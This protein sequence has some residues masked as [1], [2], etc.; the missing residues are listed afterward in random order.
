MNVDEGRGE[1]SGM[2]PLFTGAL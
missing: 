2:P 1:K